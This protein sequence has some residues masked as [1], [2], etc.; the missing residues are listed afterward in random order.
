[1]LLGKGHEPYQIIGSRR[2][3]F[4]DHAVAAAKLDPA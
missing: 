4:S 2:L 3:P 1:M